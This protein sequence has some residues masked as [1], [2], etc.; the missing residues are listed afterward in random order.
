MKRDAPRGHARARQE[1][2]DDALVIDVGNVQ[3]HA[4]ELRNRADDFDDVV[5]A[6]GVSS[7]EGNA[8]GA[9]P[10][11][12]GAAVAVPLGGKRKTVIRWRAFQRRGHQ[13]S[14]NRLVRSW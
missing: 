4:L 2:A 11:N 8:F 1:L 14:M 6:L 13:R 10:A 12:P 7:R 9:G 5:K 3:V